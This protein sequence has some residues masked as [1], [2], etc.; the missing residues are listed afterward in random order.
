MLFLFNLKSDMPQGDKDNND[1]FSIYKWMQ[2]SPK[3]NSAMALYMSKEVES[4]TKQPSCKKVFASQEGYC[5]KQCEIQGGGQEM[6][7]TLG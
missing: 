7:V 4:N 1:E 5:E 6:V 3:V 2:R